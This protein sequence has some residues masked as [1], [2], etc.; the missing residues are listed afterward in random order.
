MQNDVFNLLATAVQIYTYVLIA[1]IVVSWLQVDRSN[2]AVQALFQ[3]T[4]P[5][6]EPFRK[7]IPPI[8]M[9]DISTIVV[10]ILLRILEA[11]LRNMAGPF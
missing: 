6:L 2:P 4:E 10:I 8:G 5:V 1:R 7:L 9:I 3:V 11:V